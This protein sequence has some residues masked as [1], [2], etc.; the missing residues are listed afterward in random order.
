HQ[1]TVWNLIVANARLSDKAA[2][3]VVKAIFEHKDDL[4]NVHK[5]AVNFSLDKQKQSNSPIPFHPG[6]IKYFAEKG[7]KVQ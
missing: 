5:E 4:V 1:A 7:V 2:Y 3:D 6:A